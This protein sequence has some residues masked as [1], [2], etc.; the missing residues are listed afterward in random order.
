MDLSQGPRIVAAGWATHGD[1]PVERYRFE[2]VWSLHHYQYALRLELAGVEHRVPRGSVSL[3]RPG[4]G[5]TFRFPRA[6]CRHRYCLFQRA[7]DRGGR[8]RQG[9]AP[10]PS[11]RIFWGGEALGVGWNAMFDRVVEWAGEERSGEPGNRV[12][13]AQAAL[14][15]MLW[16]LVE[17]EI[18]TRDRPRAGEAGEQGTAE[19]VA[20]N[21]RTRLREPLRVADLA[22]EA[23]LSHNQLTRV[24]RKRYATTV[25]GYLQAQR[26]QAAVRMLEETR[27]P[28]KV[29]A[30]EVGLSDAQRFNKAV[31]AATGR[32]PTQVRSRKG[33]AR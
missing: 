32:S 8:D 24:F 7:D 23:G 20:W 11:E 16:R 19:R 10:E 4:V 22:E 17:S 21:I 31:R 12:G 1:R 13:R 5:M 6:G 9:R 14:W 2:G 18:E 26:M 25:V 3:V 28:M 33:R 27:L 29:I 15:E 30:V